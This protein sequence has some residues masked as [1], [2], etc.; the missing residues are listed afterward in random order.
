MEVV[1]NIM[2]LSVKEM[3]KEL[4]GYMQVAVD[5]SVSEGAVKRWAYSNKIPEKY[6]EYFLRRKAGEASI[7][8]LYAM[9]QKARKSN[10]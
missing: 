1:K 3:V 7:E 9:N 6:W 8:S 5:T 2:S 4:G 10:N